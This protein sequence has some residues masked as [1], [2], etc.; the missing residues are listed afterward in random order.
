MQPVFISAI[1]Q[2]NLHSGFPLQVLDSYCTCKARMLLGSFDT[3][4]RPEIQNFKHWNAQDESGGGCPYC[5]HPGEYLVRMSSVIG[6]EF[7]LQR[8]HKKTVY[9]VQGSDAA[10]RTHEEV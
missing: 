3:K 2:L 9:P 10:E 5:H 8:D 6:V 7:S 4:A 1:V